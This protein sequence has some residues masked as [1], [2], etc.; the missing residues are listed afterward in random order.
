M[1]HDHGVTHVPKVPTKDVGLRHVVENSGEEYIGFVEKVVA[2]FAH[3]SNPSATICML[4][5]LLMPNVMA[6]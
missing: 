5:V 1:R 4:I 6:S 3:V 2:Q